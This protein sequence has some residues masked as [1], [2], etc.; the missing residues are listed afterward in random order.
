MRLVRTYHFCKV[1]HGIFS[2]CQPRLS[3][4]TSPQIGLCVTLLQYTFG[5]CKVPT[6]QGKFALMLL[7]HCRFAVPS[8]TLS[9][10]NWASHQSVFIRAAE[11]K[12]RKLVTQT[13]CFGEELL[14]VRFVS[15][16]TFVAARFLVQEGLDLDHVSLHRSLQL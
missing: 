10:V 16:Y 14:R 8:N 9:R 6:T 4:F 2:L 5:S 15:S 11:T 1:P 3:S 12:L 13:G 7:L